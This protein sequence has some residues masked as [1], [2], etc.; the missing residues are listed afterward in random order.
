MQAVIL[1]GGLG[2][3]LGPLIQRVPKP[4]VPVRSRP[5]LWHLLRWDTNGPRLLGTGGALKRAEPLLAQRFL[6]LYGDTYWPVDLAALYGAPWE[7]GVLAVM[8]V[9]GGSEEVGAPRNVAV[10]GGRVVRCDKSGASPGLTHVEAGAMALA[11]SALHLL[12]P[13][14]PS[15]LEE[16]LF[17]VSAWTSS[18]RFFDIGTPERLRHCERLRRGWS[19]A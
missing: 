2:K 3:R 10:A 15:S 1:C 19:P 12:P 5:F 16:D 13:D 18:V 6:L 11:R 9:Y 14:G 7:P 4:L 17:P 8:G